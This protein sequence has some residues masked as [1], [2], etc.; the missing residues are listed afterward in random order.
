MDKRRNYYQILHVHP[1]APVEIIKSSYRTLMQRLKQHPDLGGDHGNAALINEAYRVLTNAASR[2]QYDR[3]WQPDQSESSPESPADTSS[4]MS[5]NTSPNF[6]AYGTATP[7]T[8]TT[9]AF[10][11]RIYD[12]N[13]VSDSDATCSR[14]AS[15]L[16]PARQWRLEDSGKRA[17]NRIPAKLDITFFTTWPQPV[18]SVGQTL[19]V[20]PN[21]MRFLSQRRVDKGRNI[22]ITSSRIEAVAHVMY[23]E[24]DSSE[25]VWI[26]G[27]AFK[28]LRLTR[29]QGTFFSAKV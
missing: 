27:V 1:N 21:G 5:S 29:S 4:E 18:A 11:H 17:I 3:E 9:C 28:T 20:S 6:K 22:K 10:C 19:D 2:E 16:N 24:R 15:P 7:E 14:C 8:T 13:V 23:C 26:I 12:H 25:N